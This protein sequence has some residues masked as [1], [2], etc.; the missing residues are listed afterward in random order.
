MLTRVHNY[1]K[2]IYCEPL[3]LHLAIFI[4]SRLK[5]LYF[6]LGGLV[7]FHKGGFHHVRCL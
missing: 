4:S 7:P 3:I 1:S 5:V 6:M 2:G